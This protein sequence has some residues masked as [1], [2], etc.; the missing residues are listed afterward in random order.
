[1][2]TFWRIFA[3][4][5][6]HVFRNAWI[7]LATIFVFMMALFSVNVLLGVNAML[8]QTL[9]ILEDRIDV[10]V[11]FTTTAPVAVVNQ[12]RF[13][14]ASLPQV[15]EVTQLSADE[16]LQRFRDTH[17]A[18]SKVL[19]ALEELN[20]NPLGAQIT[21][22]AKNP[23]D[24]P[25]IIKAIQNPQYAEFINPPVYDDH[26]IA[27]ARVQEIGRSTRIVGAILVALFALFGLLIAFNAIRVAVYTQR[28]EIAIMRLVGASSFY[29]RAPFI[30]EGLWL[31]LIA[32][33][34]S[35][36][37]IYGAVLWL[38]P[39]L[40]PLFEG[41]GAGLSGF[42]IGQAPLIIAVEGGSLI[43]LVMMVSW[44]AVGRYI[45]R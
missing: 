14:L 5:W 6:K 7:G 22:K 30:L 45:K 40:S 16:V 17:K 35:G 33:I 23:E 11:S 1:M 38:E 8:D 39:A 4:S 20:G 42:F 24:Y 21:V 28:E 2:I 41:A 12:A 19:G 44:V 36:L 9:K 31:T 26:Q 37:A 27:I 34:F 13:Y 32:L 29:I 3:A 10:T 15:S 25:F 18:E 43:I